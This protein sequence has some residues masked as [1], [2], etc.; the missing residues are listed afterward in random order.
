MRMFVAVIIYGDYIHIAVSVYRE[1]VC[2]SKKEKR[3]GV[4]TLETS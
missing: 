3:R 4:V 1:F 2:V